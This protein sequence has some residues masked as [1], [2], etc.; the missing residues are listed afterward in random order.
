MILSFRRELNRR[1]HLGRLKREGLPEIREPENRD[2]FFSL[3]FLLI[4][5]RNG[6]Q[7]NLT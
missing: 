4:R 1:K 2:G 5:I 3:Q 7:T 6:T